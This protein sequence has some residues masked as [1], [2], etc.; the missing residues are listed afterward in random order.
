[1]K[2]TGKKQIKTSDPS[3]LWL[4]RLP[5]HVAEVTRLWKARLKWNE[6][7]SNFAEPCYG[8]QNEA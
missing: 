8:L 5:I 4:D 6:A 7:C 3:N 1:M 2:I